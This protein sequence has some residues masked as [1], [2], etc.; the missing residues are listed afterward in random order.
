MEWHPCMGHMFVPCRGEVPASRRQAPPTTCIAKQDIHII[1]D[2]CM[3]SIV[4]MR[5]P[6]SFVCS[7]MIVVRWFVL[8]RMMH[9]GNPCIAHTRI[10][11]QAPRH[12]QHTP[13]IVLPAL[14]GVPPARDVC[15]TIT[16]VIQMPRCVIR[17]IPEACPNISEVI[18]TASP[19]RVSLGPRLVSPHPRIFHPARRTFR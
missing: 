17:H 1:H 5:F 12:A 10:A 16:R 2:G 3:Q 4:A 9:G 7:I 8:I 11:N 6:F 18:P 19:F 13:S 15:I 14:E